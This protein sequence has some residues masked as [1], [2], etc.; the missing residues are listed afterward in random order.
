MIIECLGYKISFI[1][2]KMWY[3]KMEYDNKEYCI[4]NP[5][6]GDMSLL[7]MIWSKENK[8][9][10]TD[11]SDAESKKIA[12]LIPT[13]KK[14]QKELSADEEASFFTQH[15]IK[16]EKE[17]IVKRKKLT[18]SSDEVNEL[19]NLLQEKIF[20]EGKL[21][22]LPKEILE[23]TIYKELIGYKFKFICD[24]YHKNDGQ[25]V[26]YFFTFKKDDK[27]TTFS[28]EMCLMVGFNYNE[29]LKIK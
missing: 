25:M 19:L 4:V 26:E 15:T 2:K 27:I 17:I 24:G 9:E 1:G 7:E 8:L 11:F 16:Q 10:N 21:K 14:K 6:W 12:K 5:Q 18:Y 13:I 20:D 23:N 29:T 3:Y 22:L 28:T